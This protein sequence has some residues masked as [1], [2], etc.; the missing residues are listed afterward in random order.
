M[1][2]KVTA[3]RPNRIAV[4]PDSFVAQQEFLARNYRVVSLEAVRRWFRGE[5][6]LPARATLLTFDD[7][8]LD[9]LEIAH[10]VLERLGHPAAIFVP[11][12]FIGSATPL[13][14]DAGLPVRNATVNWEQLGA[15]RG[16]F[17]IGSHACSHRPLTRVP[18]ADARREIVASKRMLEERLGQ[19]VYAF[20][21]PKG[22]IGDFNP[23]LEEAVRAA[24][25]ELAFTTIPAINRADA[26]ALG[27][28]RHNV[29]DY[30][31]PYFAALLDGRAELL[32]LKDTRLGYRAKLT[33]NRLRRRSA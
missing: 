26:R 30:G 29:E 4:T 32:R 2:H 10:P 8:Y 15:L 16:V 24:G 27:I 5:E 13:P 12:D 31:L 22:S 14:H 33:L 11:T 21:Y 28:A 3:V 19:P 1:Y 17:E 20:S 25:Y 7:G 6:E 23:R 9:N 18:F